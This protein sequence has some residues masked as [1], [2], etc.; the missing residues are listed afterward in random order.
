MVD[1]HED[2]IGG[3]REVRFESLDSPICGNRPEGHLVVLCPLSLDGGKWKLLVQAE[4][5]ESLGEAAL[6]G[7]ACIGDSIGC[8]G[9]VVSVACTS[10]RRL[11]RRR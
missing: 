5:G 10:A 7:G 6:Q 8:V 9:G 1:I 4:A 11:R 2:G 3:H